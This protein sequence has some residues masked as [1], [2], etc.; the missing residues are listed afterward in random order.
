MKSN[1]LLK[2]GDFGL[3]T[4]FLDKSKTF[5]QAGTYHYMAPEIFNGKGYAFEADIW[6]LGVLLYNLCTFEYPFMPK[7]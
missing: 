5:S 1:G 4:D 2:V 3:T 6:A 7:N